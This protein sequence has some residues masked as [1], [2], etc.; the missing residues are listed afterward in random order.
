MRWRKRP[1]RRL[2][3]CLKP[4]PRKSLILFYFGAS[5]GRV[6]RALYLGAGPVRRSIALLL[7]GLLPAPSERNCPGRAGQ[8][9]IP[10]DVHLYYAHYRATAT[11]SYFS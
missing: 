4:D 6:G 5:S 8:P 2:N 3:I 7:S 1:A 11:Q 10:D 9:L